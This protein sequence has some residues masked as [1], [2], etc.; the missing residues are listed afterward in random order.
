MKEK[1]KA[2]TNFDIIES[3]DFI[4]DRLDGYRE[5][6]IGEKHNDASYDEEWDEICTAMAWIEDACG[7]ERKDGFLEPKTKE[8]K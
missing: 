3:L 1:A 5:D 8:R 4:W 2:P 6:C 7:L